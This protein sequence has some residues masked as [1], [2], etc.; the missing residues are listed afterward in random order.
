MAEDDAQ[1]TRTEPDRPS[2]DAFVRSA[3]ARM[4]YQPLQ[5]PAAP[6]LVPAMRADEALQFLGRHQLGKMLGA[7]SGVVLDLHP[8]H[9]HDF[10]VAV[11]RTRSLIGQLRTALLGSVHDHFKAE[12]GWLADVTGP[13]RDLD[14][15]SEAMKGY[16]QWVSPEIQTRGL[17]AL[18]SHLVRLRG[19]AHR[20]L[21]QALESERY[22]LLVREWQGFLSA[23]L[24]YTPHTETAGYSIESVARQRIAHKAQR[25]FR[26]RG[27]IGTHTPPAELHRLRI[28]FKKLRYL[29]E[30][31]RDLFSAE[32]IDPLI[33]QLKQIQDGLGAI[34]DLR[35]HHAL[36]IGFATDPGA[37]AAEPHALVATGEILRGL[38]QQSDQHIERF[39]KTFRAFTRKTNRRTYA[40]LA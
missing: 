20:L 30:F 40:R 21:V 31:F 8:E 32:V 27:H 22:R 37:L 10:R 35:T 15:L 23:P 6:G 36:L 38:T 33:A 39:A 12:F 25:I 5:P 1:I 34:N 19:P 24:P 4:W 14:V 28:E 2:R 3:R 18:E 29:L 9:V 26:K 13:T 16:A 11:R 7:Q 17:A